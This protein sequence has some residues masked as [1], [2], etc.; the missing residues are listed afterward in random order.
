MSTKSFD[1]LINSSRNDIWR[2][3]EFFDQVEQGSHITIQKGA[4]PVEKIGKMLAKREDKSATGSHKFRSLEYQLSCLA[5]ESVHKAVLSSSGNA[6]ISAS[7]ILS[8]DSNLKLFVFLSQKTA[9]EKL[10]A[11]KLAPNLIPIL[12]SKPLR[13]AKY[14]IKHFNLKDLRPSRDRNA[15]IGFRSLGFEIFEQNPE[16]GNIFS[17]A[18]S[19]ASI[20]G[21]TEAYET[22]KKLGAIKKTPKLFAV[23]S[24][25][26]L[27]GGLSG[28]SSMSSG[29]KEL[30]AL[31]SPKG[32]GVS[33]GHEWTQV[34]VS[35]AE[36]LSTR[37]RHPQL[38]TSNEGVASLAA[39]EKLNPKGETLVVLT[40]KI[41]KEGKP[42]LSKF[43][44]AENFSKIDKIVAQHV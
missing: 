13:L 37:Q 18:T 32:E 41:W 17:F 34:N 5:S 35:D 31:R 10:A 4:T 25:G 21:I 44:E 26:Q 30:P 6:A 1:D 28:Q 39:A 14:A 38:E 8:Q 42:D 36:I 11:I 12:S 2:Y 7:R 15:Q 27:A 3:A 19:F 16:I 9:P 23:T 43:S 40:G 33:S 20:R 24:S 29:Q 22:L